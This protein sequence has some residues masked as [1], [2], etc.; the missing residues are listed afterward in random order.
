MTKYEFIN[1]LIP[2]ILESYSHWWPRDLLALAT[3]SP[4]WLI[5]ARKRL[6]AHPTI[7][8]FPASTLLARTLAENPFLI[9]LI[10]GITLRPMKTSDL[11]PRLQNHASSNLRSLLALKGLSCVTLGG[12]LAVKA[13]RYLKLIAVPEA[14]DE[15][16]VDGSL[17][18]HR[19]SCPPSLE[20]DESMAF[21]FPNLRKLRLTRVELVI[22]PPSLRRFPLSFSSLYLENVNITYGFLPHL[23]NGARS[24]E[25]LHVN[26]KDAAVYDEQIQLV[27]ASCAVGHLHYEVERERHANALVLDGETYN[28]KALH[29]L[30][31]RGLFV[32]LGFVTGISMMCRNLV[33]LVVCGR[34]VRVGAEEWT[35]L[36]AGGGFE[37]VRRLGL[38]WGNWRVEEVEQVRTACVSRGIGV[39]M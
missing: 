3:V 13:A 27:L 21:Q 10:K 34:E 7:H 23:L 32:D 39:V 22:S 26:T 24:L 5:H 12:E 31:L 16:H 29:C 14:V 6:Y 19:L 20:W 11:A 4:C 33:E 28:T 17:V 15:L 36:I 18:G 35:T 9:P 1:D 25:Q 8:S 37:S 2:L 30:H 38:P